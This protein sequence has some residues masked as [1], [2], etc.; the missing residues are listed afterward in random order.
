MLFKKDALIIFFTDIYC[1]H[2]QSVSCGESP[3]KSNSG[4][5]SPAV[6]ACLKN[7]LVPEVGGVGVSDHITVFLL[8]ILQLENA[9]YDDTED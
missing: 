5:V 2:R 6:F 4:A 7:I 9:P 3:D 8:V 1:K